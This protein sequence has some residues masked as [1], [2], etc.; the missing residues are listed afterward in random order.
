MTLKF[1]SLALNMSFKRKGDFWNSNLVSIHLLGREIMLKPEK[2]TNILSMIVWKLFL[3][4]TSFKM[5]RNS[6]NDY[7]SVENDKTSSQILRPIGPNPPR[8]T[9]SKSLLIIIKPAKLILK[10]LLPYALWGIYLSFL[11][12]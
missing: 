2:S 9:I 12:D 3:A 11:N 1:K 5:L 8:P 4:F 7:S 6:E 10:S